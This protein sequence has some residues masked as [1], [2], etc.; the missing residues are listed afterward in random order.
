MCVTVKF[1]YDKYYCRLTDKR[2]LHL[3]TQKYLVRSSGPGFVDTSR[4]QKAKKQIHIEN[5]TFA[6]RQRFG[7]YKLRR[8]WKYCAIR[9]MN[10]RAK[11]WTFN[12]HTPARKKHVDNYSE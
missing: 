1:R 5:R 12:E 2:L 4:M 8:E 3:Y 10:E 6:V 11:Q 9:P 7:V